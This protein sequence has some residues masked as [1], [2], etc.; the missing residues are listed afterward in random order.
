MNIFSQ[1]KGL[2]KEQYVIFISKLIDNLGSMIGPLLTII[3][4][5][6]LDMNASEI[7]MY[8]LVITVLSLPISL[9]GGRLTDKVNKK[10][11]I[12]IG[13]ITTSILYITCGIIGLNRTTLILYI[14]GSLIQTAESSAY[15]SLVADF[16]TSDDREKAYSLNYL[17]ANLG[18]MLAPT[19]GGLLITNHLNLMFIL[20]GTSQLLSIII[21]DIYIKDTRPI[22]DTSN[23]YEKK[24]EEGNVFDILKQ[25]KVLIAF[26]I[27]FAVSITTYCMWGY[28]LPL[29]LTKV[30]GEAGSIYYG[31]MS[32]L[33][34]IVVVLCTAPITS[35]ITKTTSINRMIIGNIFEV[36]GL[37]LF[38]IF[39]KTPV[40]YYFAIIIFT[41]GEIVNT[42]TTSPH[43]SKRIPVNYRGR[44][45]SMLYVIENVFIS[46]GEIIIGKV[47]DNVGLNSAWI[48]VIVVGILSII[49]YQ[50]TKRSDEKSFPDL[51]KER[52]I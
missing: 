26:M 49:A 18:L 27:I 19:I 45:S 22:I 35:L 11:I 37:T 6:K 21:F 34:C 2:R 13:D 29:S 7:A 32:S 25:N 12:N 4:S 39:I 43:L 3:L 51:Y 40:L 8:S 41:F 48:I 42:I 14:I 52:G 10:L 31:T 33:N 50:L 9:F 38:F 47:F 28:L 36:L 24:L 15:E 44:I 17:G 30:Q 20:T 46:I 5:I 1:Y 23:K 16:C